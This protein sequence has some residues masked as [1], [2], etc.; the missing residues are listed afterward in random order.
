M[1]SRWNFISTFSHCLRG[2]GDD[3]RWPV[4]WTS[5]MHFRDD[6]RGGGE[7]KRK[8]RDKT[9]YTLPCGVARCTPRSRRCQR[10]SCW[11][12]GYCLLAPV[13]SWTSAVWSALAADAAGPPLSPRPRAGEPGRGSSWRWFS[14]TVQSVP[15]NTDTE[16]LK[17]KVPG[18]RQL[19]FESAVTAQNGKQSSNFILSSSC[20]LNVKTW[21]RNV[22][23]MH[24]SSACPRGRPPGWPGGL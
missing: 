3:E 20:S 9:S 18:V 11:S 10:R 4:E 13:D 17:W 19:E 15:R 1:H 24:M 16:S 23:V 12:A 21:P 8:R 22:L 14:R 7:K 6:P 5:K 2:H